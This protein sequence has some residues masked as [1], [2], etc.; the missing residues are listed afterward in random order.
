MLSHRQGIPTNIL[1]IHTEYICHLVYCGLLQ[2]LLLANR[3]CNTNIQISVL[4]AYAS[5]A[6]VLELLFVDHIMH[7]SLLLNESVPWLEAT[8]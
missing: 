4:P 8:S 5:D 3:I 7:V 2:K 1:A 6:V